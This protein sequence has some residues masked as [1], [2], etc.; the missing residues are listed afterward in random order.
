MALLELQGIKKNYYQGKVTVPALRGI[1]LEIARGEFTA[2]AGP[3]G[4]GKTTL[5]NLIG[6]LD[7][8]S[9][10]VIRFDGRELSRLSGDRRG[11]HP[12]CRLFLGAG[13]A[14]HRSYSEAGTSVGGFTRHRRREGGNP[15]AHLRRAAEH[16][17]GGD[18][19]DGCGGQPEFRLPGL[20]LA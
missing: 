14:A 2:I 1:D 7:T 16:G 8:A 15:A 17:L 6:C 3:S 20:H 13:Q 9:D 11:A 5:L 18:P 19:R 12:R 10:G 4:S